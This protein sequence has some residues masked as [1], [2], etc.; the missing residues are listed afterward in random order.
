MSTSSQRV[1][2]PILTPQV[3]L[4]TPEEHAPS[5]RR[6]LWQWL[7]QTLPTVAVMSL[8]AGL[9]VW[10][11]ETDWTMPKFSALIGAEKTE[12]PD[13][14]DKHNVPESICVEC[15]QKLLEPQPD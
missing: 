10:G 14:C 2:T 11:H 15:N 3:A 12:E 13:W 9:A 5:E 8:I 1:S 6:T 4:A 7:S